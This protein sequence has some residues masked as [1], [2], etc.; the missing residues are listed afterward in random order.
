M[1]PIF[2]TNQSQWIIKG[3]LS[4]SLLTGILLSFPSLGP[5]EAAQAAT[6]QV[7]ATE[8]DQFRQIPQPIGLKVGVAAAGL[9]LVGLE[10]WWFLFD[11]AIKDIRDYD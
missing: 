4:A 7:S 5:L 11:K 1:K 8:T 9:S 3:F 10:L 2:S 6:D